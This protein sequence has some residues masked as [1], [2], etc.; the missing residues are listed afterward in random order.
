MMKKIMILGGGENQLPLIQ[1]AKELGYYI[2]VCDMREELE[3]VQLADQHVKINYTD[4]EAVLQAA[5]ECNIDGITSNSEPAMLSVAYVAETLGLPGNSVES[6]DTLLSKSKF[7]QLQKKAGVFAPEHVLVDTVE[8]L[9]SY[10]ATFRYPVIVK[11]EACSGTRGTT[12]LTQYDEVALR[13]AFTVC[14]AFSRTERVSMEEYVEMP[15]LRVNDADVFVVEDDILWDGTLWED[16]SPDAPMLPMT[17]IYPMALS[18]ADFSLVRKTVNQIL[19]A[20][21][22]RLG[23]FNVETYFTPEHEVFVIE[24]N[25]RQAGNYIPQLIKE[26]T[27]VDMAKLLVSTAVG[28]LTYYNQLKTYQREYNFITCQVVFAKRSGIY[29]GLYID[30]EVQPYVQWIKQPVDVGAFVEE[31]INAGQALAFVDMKFPSY[32]IQ[33]KYTDE[34][35]RYIYAE[36]EEGSAE[37]GENVNEH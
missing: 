22:V 4:R 23:E 1:T 24:I 29:T 20:A 37:I 28:D 17:E 12:K 31:G 32:E 2:I 19:R 33:H 16:R 14:Q 21:G 26:H 10:A 9:L 27:G 7:R 30:P 13:E 6:V 8:G 3:G 5:R 15:L 25:P 35:E 11:P 34:I 36:I 18:E